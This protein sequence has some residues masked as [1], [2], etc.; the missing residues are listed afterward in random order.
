MKSI[1][2][3]NVGFFQHHRTVTV[4]S[5]HTKLQALWDHKTIKAKITEQNLEYHW[6]FLFLIVT[7]LLTKE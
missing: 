3:E 2:S 1:L 5:I 7:P 6:S 4:Y